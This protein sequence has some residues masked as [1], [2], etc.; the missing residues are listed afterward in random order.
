MKYFVTCFVVLVGLKPSK[1]YQSFVVNFE[2]VALGEVCVQYFGLVMGSLTKAL[3]LTAVHLSY[4][5][6]FCVLLW[7]LK[8]SL[9][10]FPKDYDSK[11]TIGAVSTLG[12]AF[13]V[14]QC[15]LIGWVVKGG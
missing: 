11:G 14:V 7:Q 6:Y 9:D 13:F 5:V 3:R 2:S 15:L 10:G 12:I 4:I 1:S 8:K